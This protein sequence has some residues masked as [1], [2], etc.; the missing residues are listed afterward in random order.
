MWRKSWLVIM[1][2]LMVVSTVLTACSSSGKP[3]ATGA[4][5][6]PNTSTS[7]SASGSSAPKGA[8]IVLGTICS[9]TGPAASATGDD[10]AT[11]TAWQDMVNA[12]GGINGHPVKIIVKDDT[13]SPTLA[14]QDAKQLVEQNKIMAL[15]GMGSVVPSAFAG[16]M[17]HAG[18]PVIG[19]IT[20]DNTMVTNPDF[21][22]VGSNLTVVT[23][24]FLK[25]AEKVG[26]NG[27]GVAYCAEFPACKA[28][29]QIAS[30]EASTSGGV[31]VSSTTLSQ[32]TPN[33]LSQCLAIK[34]S[35]VGSVEVAG[36][37]TETQRLV[38]DCAQQGVKVNYVQVEWTIAQQEIR[39]PNFSGMLLLGA[40]A[41]YE[42]AS[43]PG[44]AQFL[45]ALNKYA[46]GTTANAEFTPNAYMSWLGLQLFA[47]ASQAAGGFTPTS[48][49]AD[50][51]KGL[52]DLRG[53]TLDGSTPPLTYTPD[54]PTVLSCYF[55]SQV[56]NGAVT[57]P[58]GTQAQCL[59]TAE[60]TGV[61][62]A[63]AR[64]G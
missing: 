28:A 38:D 45:N 26:G 15:V 23:A 3:S 35:G 63:I 60:L 34:S 62:R 41:P 49:P 18:I 39:D 22:P 55:V 50:V 61:K 24:G 16:Y 8:A 31:K 30:T 11:Y 12:S 33:F 57:Y 59:S 5:S 47:A 20:S 44:T 46:A 58:E 1:A 7:S 29:Y 27:F 64:L 56:K 53:T 21:Y 10:Q 36:I 9:C 32:S 17:Q 40:D 37:P 42:D 4:T 48:T 43:V 25:N 52:Y 6:L 13:G 51:K 14:L 2:S 19:G 54:Q